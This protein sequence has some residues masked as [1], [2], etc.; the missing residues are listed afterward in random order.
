MTSLKKEEHSFLIT[1]FYS[2]FDCVDDRL[3]MLTILLGA[4]QIENDEHFL[5][6]L[7]C[8]TA[9]LKSEVECEK[10]HDVR[11]DDCIAKL[12]GLLPRGPCQKTFER[13]LDHF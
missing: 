5:N 9:L 7:F 6:C 3:H 8:I 13:S 2:L 4:S 10:Q 11:I 1:E 12:V